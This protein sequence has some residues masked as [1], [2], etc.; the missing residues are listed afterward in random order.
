MMKRL[1]LLCALVSAALVSACGPQGGVSKEQVDQMMATR[2]LESLSEE[3]VE[4]AGFKFVRNGTDLYTY[5]DGQPASTLTLKAGQN[6]AI[7]VL[8]LDETG[9]IIDMSVHAPGE[10]NARVL[11]SNNRVVKY[12]ATNYFTGTLSAVGAGS[13]TVTVNLV[14]EDHPDYTASFPVSVTF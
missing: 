7:E 2:Y 12:S 5:V 6:Y 4:A 10:F 13:A 14:H 11:S 9:A 3:H 1:S 8:Y